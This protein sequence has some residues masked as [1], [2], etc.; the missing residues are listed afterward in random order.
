LSSCR[1]DRVP[2]RYGIKDKTIK[3]WE[4]AT[5]LSTE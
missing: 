4:I 1:C 3:L 5:A 2:L